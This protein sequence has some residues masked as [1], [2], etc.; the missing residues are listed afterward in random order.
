MFDASTANVKTQNMLRVKSSIE[1]AKIC[2]T[3][4]DHNKYL[5]SKA[6]FRI[7]CRQKALNQ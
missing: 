5:N 2:T 3:A 6:N 7:C 1:W 4:Q